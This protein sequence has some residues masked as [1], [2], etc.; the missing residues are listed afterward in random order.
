M[1]YQALSQARY[2]PYAKGES[3]ESNR[4]PPCSDGLACAGLAVTLANVRAT[5]QVYLYGSVESKLCLTQNNDLDLT[6]VLGAPGQAPQ[7]PIEPAE[8]VKELGE[9]L[10][11]Q[12]M[13]VGVHVIICCTCLCKPP[14]VHPSF[15]WGFVA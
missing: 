1:R 6:L 10:E 4:G 14:V 12:G 2:T 7:E 3:W 5:V 8:V 13:Q 15:A 9:A 11:Q